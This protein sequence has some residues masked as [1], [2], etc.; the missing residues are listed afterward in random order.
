MRWL[1]DVAVMAALV[2]LFGLA[3]MARAEKSGKD[4][5]L[6]QKCTK[7]HSIDSEK[8]AKKEEKGEDEEAE[9]EEGTKPPDLSGAGKSHD[10]AWITKWLQKQVATD[11]GKKHKPKFKGTEAELKTVADYLAGLKKGSAGGK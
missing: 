7:C 10:A 11:K 1:R 2:F 8:I 5:F 6:E 9:E 3:G 4:V